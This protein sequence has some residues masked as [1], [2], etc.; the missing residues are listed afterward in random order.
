MNSCDVM[1]VGG[2]TA[3][4]SAAIT[5]ARTGAKTL[6]AEKCA[7]P[8][9]Q[10]RAGLNFPVCGLFDSSAQLLNG[11]LSRE[12]YDRFNISPQR[13]GR[14]FVWPSPVQELLDG[15]NELMGAE[16]NLTVW[17]KCNVSD[18]QEVN[19]R[20]TEVR[21]AGQTVRPGVV[22]DCSGDGTVVQK[23]SAEM[24]C[25]EEGQ[26][27]G[28]SIRLNNVKDADEMLAVQVPYVL[29]RSELPDY[30]SFTSFALPGFLKL[31]VPPEI[32][33]KDLAQDAA[34]VIDVLR[35]KIPAFK[36]CQIAETSPCVLQRE[37]TRLKGK[38][39]LTEQDVL[40]GK[41]F[42][43]GIARSAWPIEVWHRTHGQQ[44]QYLPDGTCYDIPLRCLLSETVKNLLAAGRTI[45]ATSGA[46]A[47]SRVMGTCIALG[48]AA[49][50]QAAEQYA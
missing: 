4:M 26:L 12:L 15:F 6:L 33:E 41:T 35:K 13:M 17:T 34:A 2:G 14:V 1:I 19:G 43:D 24:I 45:S 36:T 44:L 23:C 18:V 46:L 38:Y 5:A 48:E 9:G 7:E 16:K 39:V 25:P 28:Y 31:S 11:G 22:I 3:G 40:S 32:S 29:R 37:G 10:L 49:G 30:L 20:I 50:R 42:S 47:S 27:A 8:G 21:M